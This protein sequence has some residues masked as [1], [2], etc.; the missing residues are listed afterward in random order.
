MKSQILFCLSYSNYF[1]Q[2]TLVCEL[3]FGKP[4]AEYRVIL[5][6]DVETESMHCFNVNV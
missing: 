6:H 2:L 4:L 1:F 5:K 3:W